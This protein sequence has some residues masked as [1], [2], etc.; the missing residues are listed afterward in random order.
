M[1][2][3]PWIH[4]SFTAP[5]TTTGR[6]ALVPPPP[7]HY[8]GWLLNVAFR[9]DAAAAAAL[10][11]PAAGQATGRGCVHFADWQATTDGHELLDPV[12]AQY[13][14]TIVVLELERPDGSRCMYCPAIWVDQDISMLRGLLQGWPKK[15]GS[16]WLTRSLPLDHPA[17]APCRAGSRLGASLAVKDRRVLEARA[18]LTGRPGLPLGF[19][20]QPTIGA[21]GWPDLRQPRQLPE[22]TLLR[23]DI[24]GRVGGDWF[25]AEATLHLLPHPAEDIGLLGELS[26]E[27][28]SAGWLGIT[29]T[30]AL[31]V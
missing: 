10:V 4:R 17:A 29:V 30:G 19:L 25:D 28:A 21:V 31:D 3:S 7:W 13:R 22:I 11:P 16:T 6:S 15:M 8:A 5:F 27:Q 2:A 26:A 20:A 1:H 23:A 12:M 18:T 14:E 9:F 24:Q